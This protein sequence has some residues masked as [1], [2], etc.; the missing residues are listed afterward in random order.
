MPSITVREYH[1]ESG[2]LVSNV[3]A[4]NFGRVTAGTTSGVKVLDVVFNEVSEVGD[5]KI[6]LISSGNLTVNPNPQ[7]INEDGSAGNGFFGIESSADFDPVIASGP[8]SRHFAGINGTIT[9]DNANNVS[10]DNRSRNLSDYIYLDVE[11]GAS[12]VGTGNGAYKVFFDY[13]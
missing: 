10:V 6:G 13:S 2:A 8:L 7:D 5:I 4:L 12:N 1:P 11:I 3:S 9:A